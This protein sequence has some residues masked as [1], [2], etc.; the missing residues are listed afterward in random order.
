MIKNLISN[1]FKLIDFLKFQTNLGLPQY[2]LGTTTEPR[3]L[4]NY[5][6][7]N[8]GDVPTKYCLHDSSGSKDITREQFMEL[9]NV[10]TTAKSK[11]GRR[12]RETSSG[13]QR[14]KSSKSKSS[15]ATKKEI[16]G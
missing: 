14:I 9:F 1:F 12:K 4:P 10:K 8:L 5:K 3:P 13:K 15:K 6:E 2:H 7:Y 11:Q 16:K